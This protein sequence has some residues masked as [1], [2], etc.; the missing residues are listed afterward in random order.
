MK[1]YESGANMEYLIEKLD[2][3]NYKKCANIW[4]MDKQPNAQQWFNEIV[5]GNRIVFVYKV[6]DD[7]I[8]EGA[9]VF[10]NEDPD[11]TIKGQRIYL[12]RM[13]VKSEYRHKGIGGIIIDYLVNYAKQIGYKEMSLGVDIDNI[14][15]RHLYEKK[16]F[17]NIIFEGEDEY[18]KYVKLIKTL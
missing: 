4:N 5:A 11:Y 2:P 1:L 15:A 16:G 12:S 18:S 13:I 3:S 17:T 10:E 9:L 7:F 6:N 14:R 8:G